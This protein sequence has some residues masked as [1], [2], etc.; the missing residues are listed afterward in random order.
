MNELGLFPTPLMT[1]DLCHF[2]L[3]WLTGASASHPA[4]LLSVLELWLMGRSVWD[5]GMEG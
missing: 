4:P 2:S 5:L 3:R 1:S